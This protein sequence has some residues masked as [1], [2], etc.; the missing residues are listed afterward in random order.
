[1]KALSRPGIF[2][3]LSIVDWT[4]LVD[5]RTFRFYPQ[6]LP[7]KDTDDVLGSS[8]YKTG[9]SSGAAIISSTDLV[10]TRHVQKCEWPV[11]GLTPLL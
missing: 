8:F 2:H 9:S 7:L 4:G 6:K 1:M 3:D 5:L 10:D 11:K